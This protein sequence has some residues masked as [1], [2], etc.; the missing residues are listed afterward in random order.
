MWRRAAARARHEILKVLSKPAFKA[1]YFFL[2][3]G[4]SKTS[5]RWVAVAWSS[6]L[7]R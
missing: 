5:R 6:A 2:V 7:T 3:G 1:L 4:S